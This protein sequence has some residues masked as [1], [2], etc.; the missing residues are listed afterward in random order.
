MCEPVDLV[1]ALRREGA[2]KG[3]Y[4]RT[5]KGHLPQCAND[6]PL[7]SRLVP[8]YTGTDERDREDF[9]KWLDIG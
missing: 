1:I 9:S 8:W 5:I 3:P 4:N 6:L 7:N 2:A